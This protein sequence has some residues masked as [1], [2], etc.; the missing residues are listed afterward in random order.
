MTGIEIAA[1]KFRNQLNRLF[2]N[3]NKRPFASAIITAA[4]SGIRMGG[5]SKQRVLLAGNPCLLYSL[6]AFEQCEGIDEIIITAKSGEEAE[7]QELCQANCISKLKRVV[8]GGQTRQ[9]SV[10]NGFSYVNRNAELV[11]IH[12]AARP[13]IKPSAIQSLLD[14][15]KRYGAA[16]A[17]ERMVDTVKLGN[18]KDMVV[19][20]IPREELFTVQTPQVFKC[21]LYRVSLA[22]AEKDGIAVTDDC[23]LA[24]HAGFPIKLCQISSCNLKL[25]RPEDARI[26]SA[27]LE[28]RKNG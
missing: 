15:A 7:I 9:E 13:L 23:S 12:D 2:P 14:A 6:Q 17:A 1:V 27:I 3:G 24:E 4:G 26:L 28:E 11:A 8:T 25:T 18:G 16:C 21:D 5:V 19:K 10:K 20:T 22:L